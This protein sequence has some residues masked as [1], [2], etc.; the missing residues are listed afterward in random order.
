M[1]L[2]SD[3]EVL[4]AAYK[5]SGRAFVRLVRKDEGMEVS[6]E[7]KFP[8]D[9]SQRMM[10]EFENELL[11]QRLRTIVAAETSGIRDLIMAHAL[12]NAVLIRPDLESGLPAKR[13]A[14]SD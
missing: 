11:D 7:S 6:L 4:K 3:E 5:F 8:N 12:S 9:D 2:Y 1:T 13:R 14:I 10:G